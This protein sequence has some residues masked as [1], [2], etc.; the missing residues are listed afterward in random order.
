M[1]FLSVLVY[2]I[3]RPIIIELELKLLHY[4]YVFVTELSIRFIAFRHL[5]E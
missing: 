2:K 4:I 3:L 1:I 5:I